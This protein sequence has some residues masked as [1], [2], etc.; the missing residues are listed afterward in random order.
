MNAH[1]HPIPL[2]PSLRR[3]A[4]HSSAGAQRGMAS[5]IVAVI[6]FVAMGM[7]MVYANR[8]LV[9]E[10][11]ISANQYR[12][13]L[14]M[15]AAEAGLEWATAMLNKQENI[16]A[17]CTT[18]ATV[19]DVRFKAKYLTADTTTGVITPRAG[20]VHA[21]CVANQTGAGWT[22]S[23]PAAGTAPNPAAAA[24]TSG[25]QPS[26]AVQ[27]QASPTSRTVRLVS[28]G[29]TS[30][31]TDA[32]CTGDGVATVTVALGGVPGLP[33]PPASP[34][35]ARG[36]V[37]IGNAALGVINGDPSSNGITI[38]A[39]MAIDAPNVRVTTVPGSPPQAS[40]VGN[41]PTLRDTSEEQMFSTFFGMSKDAYKTLPSV[42]RFAC[43]CTEA[44]ITTAYAQGVRQFWLDGNLSMNANIT[45][46]SE[47]DPVLVIVDGNVEM[48]G[49]LRIFGLIYSTAMTWDNTGGGSALMQGAAISEGNYSGNGTPDYFYDPRVLVALRDQ[50][51]FVRV[52]GSWRDF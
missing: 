21:A 47:T 2:T 14:A 10:G 18:S 43:P 28:Y 27:F 41:D 23:C 31:I 38:N 52:P 24:P 7:A 29:C 35:T 42:R 45:I 39:G 46:G 51:S 4:P 44:T 48:R 15:E 36:S 16:N 20:I 50:A 40:L 30:P 12:A 6:I 9:M 26:F 3:R 33:T 34:L 49:D 13:T 25:F 17:S 19:G 32:T 37:S 22:C 11:R 5:L 1:H 8:N